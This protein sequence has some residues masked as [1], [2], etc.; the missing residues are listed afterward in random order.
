MM[1]F[2]WIVTHADLYVDTSFQRNILSP[3]SGLKWQCW[4]VKKCV[5][6]HEEQ[7]IGNGTVIHL[8][9]SLST[10]CIHTSF[11]RFTE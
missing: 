3:S 7:V 2:F 9:C 10:E 11:V 1:L 8:L 5:G 4:D 6:S